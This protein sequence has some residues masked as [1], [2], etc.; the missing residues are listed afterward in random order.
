MFRILS[1]SRPYSYSLRKRMATVCAHAYVR[2][3]LGLQVVGL[4]VCA[5]KLVGL[6]VC[7]RTRVL[8]HASQGRTLDYGLS[9][10]ACIICAGCCSMNMQLR[11]GFALFIL[12]IITVIPMYTVA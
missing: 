9:P 11:Q 1:V 3:P 7:A 2:R 12:Y 5:R 8:Q 4:G 10:N 6:G